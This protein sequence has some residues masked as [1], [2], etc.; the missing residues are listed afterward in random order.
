MIEFLPATKNP[1]IDRNL[2]F[3]WA[4][5]LKEINEDPRVLVWPSQEL[6]GVQ[7]ELCALEY[8]GKPTQKLKAQ[9]GPPF[10]SFRTKMSFPIQST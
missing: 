5:A 7:T 2:I 6:A 4:S 3:L 9:D 10:N 8:R 1:S